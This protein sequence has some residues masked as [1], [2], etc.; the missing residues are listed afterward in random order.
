[1][2]DIEHVAEEVQS[3]AAI[4]GE[5]FCWDGCSRV[6]EVRAQGLHAAPAAPAAAAAAW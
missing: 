3:L 4:Y 2:D 6:C 1:M 5:D